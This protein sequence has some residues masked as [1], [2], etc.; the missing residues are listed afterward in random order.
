MTPGESGVAV[1][2]V[3]TVCEDRDCEICGGE[4]V[5][6]FDEHATGL[7]EAIEDPAERQQAIDRAIIDEAIAGRRGASQQAIAAEVVRWGALLLRKNSVYGDSAWKR[8]M[9]APECDAGTAIRVRMSD[10]LSRLLMLLERPA[11]VTS[12]SFDDTLRD[13]GCYCLLELARPGR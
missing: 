7:H 13:F 8:P 6:G 3:A 4:T 1:S 11:E 5:S 12:E 9:L 10:K 2:L